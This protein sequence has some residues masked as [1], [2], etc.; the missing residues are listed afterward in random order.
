VLSLSD[1]KKLKLMKDLVQPN[2]PVVLSHDQM[3]TVFVLIKRAIGE[4]IAHYIGD[5]PGA[6]DWSKVS[7]VAIQ[8]GSN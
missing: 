2:A 6:P 7:G 8:D 3:H 1:H 5:L 4:I